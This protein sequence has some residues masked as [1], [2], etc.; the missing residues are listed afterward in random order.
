MR[1]LPRRARGFAVIVGL[2][3]VVIVGILGAALASISAVQQA[4][5]ANDLL[6]VQ[7]YSAART[8]LGYGMYRAVKGGW[9]CAPST[10]S[11]ALP[12]T[13]SRFTVTVTCSSYTATQGGSSTT[14]W[15]VTATACNAP[16]AGACPGIAGP[17]Y[18]ERRVTAAITAN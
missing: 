1:S 12:G 5:Q 18:A 13:L 11:F 16:S 17:G 8:G 3:I 7:A 2:M 10:D 9:A 14:V 15:N 4:N 6:G